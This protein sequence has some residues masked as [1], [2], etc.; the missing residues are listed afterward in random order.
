MMARERDIAG[1]NQPGRHREADEQ[2][3][4]FPQQFHDI[5]ARPLV[6]KLH[7]K[8]VAAKR[9]RSEP[10]RNRAAAGNFQM[11]TAKPLRENADVLTPRA[12]HRRSS[13][14]PWHCRPCGARPPAAR[15]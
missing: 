2:A 1:A 10:L 13:I 11:V 14:P 12:P 9:I 4:Q 3:K 5:C 6:V 15:C 7:V 8:D